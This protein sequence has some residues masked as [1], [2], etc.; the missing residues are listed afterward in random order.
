V[1]RFGLGH[2][3]DPWVFAVEDTSIQL[4]WAS[5]DTRVVRARVGQATVALDHD[6]GPGSVVI[7]GLP[8]G[9]LLEVTL[10]RADGAVAW[11]Q[12]AHTLAPPPGPELFR[13]ATLSDMHLGERNFGYRGTIVE[14]PRAAEPY[15]V[16]ATRAAITELSAWGAELLVVKGDVTLSGQAEQWDLFGELMG[17]FDGPV[18]ATPGNHDGIEDTEPTGWRR[19]LE[20]PRSF[21][22]PSTAL[23][24]REGLRR[25]GLGSTE[26]VQVRDEPGIRIV[27][28][29][30]T[31][32]HRR[33]GQLD[34]AADELLAPIADAVGAVWVGLHHQLMTTP[35]PTYLPVGISRSESRRFLDRAVAA[36]P[37]LLVTSGHT[38]RNRRRTHGPVPITEVGAPKDYPGV[39]AG[40][41]VHEGGIR[42]MVRRVRAPDVLAWTDRSAD[43]A[44]G[45]WGAWS[46]GHLDERCFTHTWP[47]HRR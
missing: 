21:P 30:T 20:S 32:P 34:I 42:Q 38:H 16:R 3:R 5:L 15:S 6:G 39:W 35:V 17:S 18:M 33:E 14:Q 29:D 8:A 27:L 9:S 2:R 46:P 24:P 11:R 43:A 7:D 40:Y 41:V 36:N 13:F 19:T 4:T 37:D 23:T 45:L 25:F 44:Y 1:D 22:E 12:T 10:D 47:S 31:V 26:R 28:V